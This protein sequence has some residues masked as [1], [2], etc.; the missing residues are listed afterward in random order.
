MKKV[1]YV[2]VCDTAE[3]FRRV[4][5]FYDWSSFNEDTV[6][7]YESGG[8][9]G[10]INVVSGKPDG[11]SGE[12]FYKENASTYGPLVSYSAWAVIHGVVRKPAVTLQ[13]TPTYTAE[14]DYSRQV[15]QVGCQAVPF[16]KIKE[17]YDLTIK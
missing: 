4:A 8:R 2:I 1:S 16:D 9:K 13:L 11:Y 5:K 7:R 6:D 10:C 15:V 12:D 14:V 3:D 17:V